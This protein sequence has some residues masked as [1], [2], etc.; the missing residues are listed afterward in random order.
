MIHYGNVRG[1]IYRGQQQEAPEPE[2]LEDGEKPPKKFQSKLTKKCIGCGNAM[3][4]ERFGL[5]PLGT[6]GRHR[7]C[8][9]CTR[10][11]MKYKL[12]GYE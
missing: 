1:S 3:P 8:K 11:G 2:E 6:Y 5:D 10:A 9:K 12:E 4:L 7:Y